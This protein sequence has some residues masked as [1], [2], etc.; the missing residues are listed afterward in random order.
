MNAAIAPA[1]AVRTFQPTQRIVGREIRGERAAVELECGHVADV[2]AGEA[3]VA[4]NCQT[5]KPIEVLHG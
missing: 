3:L 1:P 5:C 2:P 4:L